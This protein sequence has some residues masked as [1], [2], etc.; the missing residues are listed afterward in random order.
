MGKI[1]GFIVEN[2]KKKIL[3]LPIEDSFGYN[4]EEGVI[5]VAD[6]V[7]RDCLNETEA[8]KSGSGVWNLFW[9][10]PKKRNPASMAS[11]TFCD[12]FVNEVSRG[13]KTP[14][15]IK[16]AF[17]NANQSIR[18]MNKH[19]G[20]TPETVDYLVNDYGG[21]VAA[22]TAERDETGQ[23]IISYGFITDCG[24]A[25]FDRD[26]NLKI[27]KTTSMDEIGK[28][29]NSQP[30][31]DW[32]NSDSRKFVRKV[33]RN[34]PKHDPSYGVLTGEDWGKIKPYLQ[35]G[36]FEKK[37]GDKLVVYSDGLN[38]IIQTGEFSDLIRYNDFSGLQKLCRRKVKSEGTLVVS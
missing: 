12:D 5:A 36:E 17:E 8:V 18:R 38:S 34:N 23:K 22:G 1:S 21:C 16:Q 4:P 31:F 7:T 30:D 2:W 37:L 6:G 3:R 20:I 35:T 27:N 10:Y 28:C 25:L 32:K 33:L 29:V 24:V 13:N 9:H 19:F 14:N 15:E 11:Q 26:G